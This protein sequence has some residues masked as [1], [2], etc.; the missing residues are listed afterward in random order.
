MALEEHRL[1]TVGV[2]DRHDVRFSRDGHLARQSFGKLPED[3]LRTNDDDLILSQDI[4]CRPN[5]VQ[6][7]LPLHRARALSWNPV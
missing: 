4:A 7:F 6:E 5:E 2:V 3:R 1:R